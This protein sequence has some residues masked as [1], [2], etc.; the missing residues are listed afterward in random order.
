MKKDIHIYIDYEL[1]NEIEKISKWNK[2]TL[3]N[4]Y[5]VLLKNGLYINNISNK[6]DLIYKL[7]LRI[8][9]NNYRKIDKLSE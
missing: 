5:A 2:S 7:L 1:S 8:T 3:S 9:N 6:L 4:T